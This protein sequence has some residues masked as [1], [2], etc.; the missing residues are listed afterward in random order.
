MSVS[1]FNAVQEF[2]IRGGDGKPVLSLRNE[3][4]AERAVSPNFG[5]RNLGVVVGIEKLD[6]PA[7]ERMP[8]LK[9]G[10]HS[11]DSVHL[12]D[13]DNDVLCGNAAARAKFDGR[14]IFRAK[15]PA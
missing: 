11:R 10:R 7:I 5:F 1:E 3:R 15:C 4:E 9:R 2:N 13:G 14:S 6:Y 12:T 8:I